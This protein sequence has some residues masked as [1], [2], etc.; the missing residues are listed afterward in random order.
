MKVKYKTR[1]DNLGKVSTTLDEMNGGQVVVGA[2]KGEHA[3]LANIHEYGCKI[4]VTDKMRAYLHGIGIHLKAST[5]TI[6]I[7]ERSF[8]RAGHDKYIDDVMDASTNALNAVMNGKMSAEAFKRLIGIQMS[9]KIKLYARDL[10]D[11]PNSQAT[12]DRKGSAN[13]LVD[14]GAMIGGIT[15]EVEK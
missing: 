5:D 4:P 2:L 6:T 9:S 3:W 8:I 1:K 15:Y 11:P 7:P 12:I 10:K 14:T 13:P